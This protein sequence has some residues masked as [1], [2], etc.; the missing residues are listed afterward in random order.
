MLKI[1]EWQMILFSYGF[2]FSLLANLSSRGGS[3]EICSNNSKSIVSPT[4]MPQ[5]L[6]NT[7]ATFQKEIDFI[8]SNFRLSCVYV[9]LNYNDF[10]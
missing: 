2:D 3:R 10:L 5:G 4:G 8:L 7:P 1:K 9:Y 6:C